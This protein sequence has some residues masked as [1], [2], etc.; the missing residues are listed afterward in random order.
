VSGNAA[1]YSDVSRRDRNARAGAR[2]SVRR[3]PML[4]ARSMTS[5]LTPSTA[6]MALNGFAGRA[7]RLCVLGGRTGLLIMDSVKAFP[8]LV[9]NARDAAMFRIKRAD[10]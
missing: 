7:G 10:A 5:G 8:V 2:A 6:S 3:W 1:A 9:A 4:S